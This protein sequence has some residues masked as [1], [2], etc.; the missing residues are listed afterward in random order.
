MKS[1]E[2]MAVGESCTVSGV[3]LTGDALKRISD[4]GLTVGADIGL[5]GVAPLGDPLLFKVRGFYMAVRKTD[6]A[7]IFVNPKIPAEKI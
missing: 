4:M 2:D 7:K 3:S 6:A 5:A 1:A